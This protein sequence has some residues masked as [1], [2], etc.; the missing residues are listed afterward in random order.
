[1][2]SLQPL[3]HFHDPVPSDKLLLESGWQEY[4]PV[5]PSVHPEQRIKIYIFNR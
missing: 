2:C 4:G 3:W 1:M 5:L